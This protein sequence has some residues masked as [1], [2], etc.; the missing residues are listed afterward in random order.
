VPAEHV[1]CGLVQPPVDGEGKV[2]DSREVMA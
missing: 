1:E 2:F